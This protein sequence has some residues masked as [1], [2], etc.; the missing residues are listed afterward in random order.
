LSWWAWLLISLGV[1]VAVW[2]AFVVWLTA[3]GKRE[4]ARAFAT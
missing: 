1:V 4:D 2:V 3:V